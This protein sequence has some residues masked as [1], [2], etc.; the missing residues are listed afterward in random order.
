MTRRE[1]IENVL[2]KYLA[3]PSSYGGLVNDLRI[4]WI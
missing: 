4:F 2:G 3:S 1:T